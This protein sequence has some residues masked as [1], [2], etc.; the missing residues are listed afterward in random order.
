MLNIV[1]HSIQFILDSLYNRT[2]TK[3]NNSRNIFY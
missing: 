2:L 3:R 1:S